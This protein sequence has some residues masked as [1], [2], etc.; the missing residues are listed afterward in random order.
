ME[1][2]NADINVMSW[3]RQTTHL[4]AS[5]ADDGEWA[6]W[7]LRQ[8]RPSSGSA[9]GKPTPIAGFNYHKEQITSVEWH[10]TD[11]SIVAVAAGD[12]TITLWDLAVELDDEESKDTAGVK[13]VP[14]QLLFVHF[15]QMVK[16]AHWHPQIPGS[17]IATGE[18]FSV[19][20]TISV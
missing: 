18:E 5:G 7:D 4:L 6:V 14:P 2:S 13:D 12:N 8:W 17:L 9:G 10:P 16:E 1:I 11:D 3:S 15:Q 19:F 20:K